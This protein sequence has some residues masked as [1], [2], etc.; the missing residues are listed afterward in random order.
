MCS[1]FNNLPVPI[2]GVPNSHRSTY[3][4][5]WS[6]TLKISKM[7]TAVWSGKRTCKSQASEDWD[8]KLIISNH[9][10]S[11][12][13][14]FSRWQFVEF[15][16]LAVFAIIIFLQFRWHHN[17]HVKPVLRQLFFFWHKIIPFHKMVFPN[18][19]SNVILLE[20][21]LLF[22]ELYWSWVLSLKTTNEPTGKNSQWGMALQWRVSLLSLRHLFSF[23]LPPVFLRPSSSFFHSLEWV[24][25]Y[26]IPS[27]DMGVVLVFSSVN[28]SVLFSSIWYTGA[29]FP[30]SGLQASQPDNDWLACK[31]SELTPCSVAAAK[32]EK[33]CRG[34]K[35]FLPTWLFLHLL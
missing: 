4:E 9:W 3:F 18:M 33:T 26:S 5:P 8:R 22:L 23:P 14:P 28:T 29:A 11:K 27:F 1:C 25:Q 31:P 7:G 24:H 15:C 6:L 10:C 12:A 2:K 21:K 19:I 17:N 34:D 32:D 35:E 16:S 20:C 30:H 13:L